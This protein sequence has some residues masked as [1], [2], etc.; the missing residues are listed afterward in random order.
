MGRRRVEG[1]EKRLRLGMVGNVNGIFVEWAC[2]LD[3]TKFLLC[4]IGW[5]D[6]IL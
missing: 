3:N 6:R 5:M 2:Q 1:P 4:W